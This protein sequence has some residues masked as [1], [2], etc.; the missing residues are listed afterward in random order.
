MDNQNGTAGETT[1]PDRNLSRFSEQVKDRD[2]PDIEQNKPLLEIRDLSVLYDDVRAVKDVSV[3]IPRKQVTAVIGPS[4]CGKST[5]LNAINRMTDLIDSCQIDGEIIFDG[6]NILTQETDVVRLRRKIGMVFQKPN[7]FPKSIYK[8]VSYGPTLHG[9]SYQKNLD[10]IVENCLKKSVLWE[11]V[12]DRLDSNAMEL[13]GGQQQRLCIARALAMEPELLLLDEPTSALDP[14]STR[15]IE[16][17]IGQLRGSYTIL[18]VTHNM[19]QAARISDYTMFLYKGEK[20]EFN[21]TEKLF[22]NPENEKTA[23]YITGRFG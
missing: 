3:K 9:L 5:F 10:E 7:P 1:S 2:E 18:I 15:K 21:P 14:A 13:S 19:Q 20:I 12:K 8:N 4:G 6:D 16:Q 11:E 22:T 17:L 23:E